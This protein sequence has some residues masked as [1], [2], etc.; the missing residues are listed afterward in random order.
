MSLLNY[1]DIVSPI[2]NGNTDDKINIHN[3][4]I[5]VERVGYAKLTSTLQTNIPVWLPSGAQSA[6]ERVSNQDKRLTIPTGAIVNSVGLRLP[7]LETNTLTPQYGRLQ[8]GATLIGTSGEYIKLA[9]DAVFTT[10]TPAIPCLGGNAYSANSSNMAQRSI[11]A[12]ADIA[13]SLINVAASN[14]PVSV[15]VSNSGNTAAGNGIRTSAGD[16]FVIVVVR[17]FESALAPTYEEMGFLSAAR[18]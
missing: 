18:G 9:A 3:G 7:A 8:P 4:L 2:L 16:A 13:A 5:L 14:T 1:S 6:Q 15:V 12:P 11:T 17:W 10:T